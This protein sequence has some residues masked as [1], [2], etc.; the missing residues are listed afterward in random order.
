[1]SI[2][3]QTEPVSGTVVEIYLRNRGIELPLPDVLRF[4]P[5]LKHPTGAFLPTMVALI[6]DGNNQPVAIH[7][8]FLATDGFGKAAVEPRKMML[9]PCRGGLCA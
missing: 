9:G 5:A 4:H 7:R 3:N 1:M 6:T 8:T 2:W